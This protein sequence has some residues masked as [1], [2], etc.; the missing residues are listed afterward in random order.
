MVPPTVMVSLS[1]SINLLGNPSRADPKAYLLVI[2]DPAKLT[3]S[4][5]HHKDNMAFCKMGSISAYLLE[6]LGHSQ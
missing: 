1:T 6:F 2:L 5:K 3:L 4:I